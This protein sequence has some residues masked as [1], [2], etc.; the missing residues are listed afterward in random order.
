MKDFKFGNL[1]NWD[2][3][4]VCDIC[5]KAVKAK[6]KIFDKV[7][8]EHEKKCQEEFMQEKINDAKAEAADSYEVPEA[9]EFK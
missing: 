5:L 7:F 9:W 4:K 3:E 6:Y 1:D 2:T 8:A